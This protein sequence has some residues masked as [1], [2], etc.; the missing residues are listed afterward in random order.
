MDI[1]GNKRRIRLNS[2]IPGMHKKEKATIHISFPKTMQMKFMG[3]DPLVINQKRSTFEGKVHVP[4]KL[5][6]WYP[7][8][9]YGKQHNASLRLDKLVYSVGLPPFVVEV[10]T[11]GH[12]FE[13][14]K[15]I[16]EDFIVNIKAWL[17]S[18]E[19]LE[20]A[21]LEFTVTLVG[22]EQVSERVFYSTDQPLDNGS[23]IL[24]TWS[25][26]PISFK[27]KL[28]L[29]YDIREFE[30]SIQKTFSYYTEGLRL[31]VSKH[32]FS[33]ISA[34]YT[35]SM[36]GIPDP[37][38]IPE[39]TFELLEEASYVSKQTKDVIRK[40]KEALHE[41]LALKPS[42]VHKQRTTESGPFQ[43][44]D[45]KL[46]KRLKILER[47]LRTYDKI[48]IKKLAKFLDIQPD[49]LELWLLSLDETIPIKIR[50]D[51]IFIDSTYVTPSMIELLD[52]KFL[53]WET[54]TS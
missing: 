31:A 6:A 18:P 11:L 26:T 53:E 17:M 21:I 32:E 20:T 42:N 10:N 23:V 9:N 35:K 12:Y 36:V 1:L 39:I 41:Y 45:D 51:D 19:L 48:S 50:G 8:T 54:Q 30:R 44:V 29:N 46:F 28:K 27:L 22:E 16:T 4:I 3:F 37:I 47:V 15:D 2:D 43:P 33:N 13:S 38:V 49:R 40:Y 25:R 5:Q 7:K 24:P 52:H 14:N 34:D